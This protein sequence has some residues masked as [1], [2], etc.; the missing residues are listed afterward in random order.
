MDSYCP[1]NQDIYLAM[2]YLL[3]VISMEEKTHDCKPKQ[4]MNTDSYED[5]VTG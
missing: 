2:Y 4:D 3:D 1:W 5:P